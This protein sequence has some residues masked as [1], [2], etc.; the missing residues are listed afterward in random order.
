MNSNKKV[1]LGFGI[2]LI[3]IIIFLVNGQGPS[4]EDGELEGLEVEIVQTDE[5]MDGLHPIVEERK[6]LLV[7][8]AEEQGIEVVITEG[9]R[10]VEEQN[11]LY[12]QGRS[13]SGNIVTN[14][15][16]GTSYHNYG[17]AIDFALV[18]E[19]GQTIWD[20]EYDGNGDGTSD[21]MEVV[22]IAKELD[23]EWGGDWKN[24]Q[25]Y[26]HLQM[27]F[28]LRIRQLQNGLRP[29]VVSE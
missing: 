17:L 3:I 27:T 4:H 15:E 19:D 11:A 7:Q 24:F 20:L 22:A 1:L 8:R 29:V 9:Y 6:N 12:R 25:D 16:G 14:A 10:S 2:L 13:E 21:W 18:N 28:G 5:E 26:P 23:F